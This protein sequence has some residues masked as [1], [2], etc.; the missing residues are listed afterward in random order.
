MILMIQNDGHWV[1]GRG[2]VKQY[3]IKKK[4]YLKKRRLESVSKAQGVY[5]GT[6][7][8]SSVQTLSSH[9]GHVRRR[10]GAQCGFGDTSLNETFA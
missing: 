10:F 2:K 8:P 7:V 1:V 9:H 5:S 6:T 3:F 4:V